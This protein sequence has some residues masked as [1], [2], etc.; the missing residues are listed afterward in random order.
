[1]NVIN[2]TSVK[3]IL[4][5]YFFQNLKIHIKMKRHTKPRELIA[6]TLYSI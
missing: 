4:K 1:M 6:H 2:S 5:A 3:P